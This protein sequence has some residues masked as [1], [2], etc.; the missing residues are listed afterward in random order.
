M[1]LL[2]LSLVALVLIFTLENYTNAAVINL[3]AKKNIES[4]PVILQL[5]EGR[6]RVIPAGVKD[7]GARLWTHSDNVIG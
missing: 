5:P 6:Y 4:N 1:K 3:D 2:K 7:G